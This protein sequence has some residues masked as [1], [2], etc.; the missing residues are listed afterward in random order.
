MFIN[1]E[2]VVLSRTS[3]LTLRAVG[4]RNP[5]DVVALE[6]LAAAAAGRAGAGRHP[7]QVRHPRHHQP[8]F[9]L[10]QRR[11]CWLQRGI[12]LRGRKS[13]FQNKH[14][15]AWYSEIYPGEV[16]RCNIVDFS[17]MYV[18]F[19]QIC[20]I[21]SCHP[22]EQ[23]WL[24]LQ[25]VQWPLPAFT[26][27]GKYW[28]RWWCWKTCSPSLKSN[29]SARVFTE[30]SSAALCSKVPSLR[31]KTFSSTG[32]RSRPSPPWESSLWRTRVFFFHDHS[33]SLITL[34]GS[35]LPRV[36]SGF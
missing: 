28:K 36:E 34:E 17:C 26:F 31:S 22:P 13:F 1:S 29:I 14:F 3:K 24:L 16:W 6:K 21:F 30:S 19:F 5:L 10:R 25:Y 35:P 2:M 11:L 12:F 18:I 4:D 27:V 15:W 33:W 32:S 9:R 8:V 23:R 7:G 20:L